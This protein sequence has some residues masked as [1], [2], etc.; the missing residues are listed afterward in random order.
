MRLTNSVFRR[1]LNFLSSRLAWPSVQKLAMPL[2]RSIWAVYFQTQT[3]CD[4]VLSLF[5]KRKERDN[6]VVLV[7]T[8]N[9]RKEEF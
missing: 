9:I 7:A 3:R 2:S 5:H 1:S 8:L 6:H 4:I